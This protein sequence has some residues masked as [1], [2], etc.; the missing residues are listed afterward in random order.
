MKIII[1]IGYIPRADLNET[2]ILPSLREER[3][4][5][6]DRDCN[7]DE[8]NNA[9]IIVINWIVDDART[10]SDGARLSEGIGRPA[11]SD[12]FAITTSKFLSE[13]VMNLTRANDVKEKTNTRAEEA[14]ILGHIKG[15]QKFLSLLIFVLPEGNNLHASS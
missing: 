15:I 3:W 8:T 12:W 5:P 4:C 9:R 6:N 7:H 1:K 14:A 13:G 10:I 11:H 2:E